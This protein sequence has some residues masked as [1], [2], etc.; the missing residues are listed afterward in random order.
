MTALLAPASAHPAEE[1]TM[2][3]PHRIDVHH[4]LVSPSWLAAM[5]IIGRTDR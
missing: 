5:D 3:E 2:T 4:H 1:S